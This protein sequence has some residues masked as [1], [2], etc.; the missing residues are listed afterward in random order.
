MVG[1]VVDAP[2]GAG[3]TQCLPDY[4]RDEDAQRAYAK[5]AKDPD[6]WESWRTAWLEGA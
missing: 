6:A 3:F 1:V 5:T 2:G 4:P